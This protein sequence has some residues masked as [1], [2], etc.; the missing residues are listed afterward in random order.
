MREAENGHAALARTKELLPSLVLLDLGMP[1]L[2]GFWFMERLRGLPGGRCLP[3]IVITAE[4]LTGEGR[5]R[6]NDVVHRSLKKSAVR[7][8]ALVEEIRL[9][10]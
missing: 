4:D 8:E 5:R 10:I 7:P 2:D 3:V 6:L 9:L 1:D